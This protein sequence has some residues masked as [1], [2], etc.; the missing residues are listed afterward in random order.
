MIRN[1]SLRITS[2]KDPLVLDLGEGDPAHMEAL[3]AQVTTKT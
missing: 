3:S 2:C 1:W